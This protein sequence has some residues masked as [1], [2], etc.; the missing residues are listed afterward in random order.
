MQGVDVMLI[1]SSTHAFSLD[2]MTLEFYEALIGD[3][4]LDK[5]KAVVLKVF[6]GKADPIFGRNSKPLT[7]EDILTKSGLSKASTLQ[8]KLCKQ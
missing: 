4:L 3:N 5:C 6:S 1:M 2:Y 8:N 7:V